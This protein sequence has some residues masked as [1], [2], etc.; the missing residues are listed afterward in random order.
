MCGESLQSSGGSVRVQRQRAVEIQPSAVWPEPA[1]T[2]EEHPAGGVVDREIDDLFQAARLL[3]GVVLEGG[4]VLP[5]LVDDVAAV[6]AVHREAGDDLVFRAHA[7]VLSCCR[8]R[9]Y[10]IFPR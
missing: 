4:V 5:H 3:V 1:I 10:I 2:V 8:N 7:K 6:T 9:I